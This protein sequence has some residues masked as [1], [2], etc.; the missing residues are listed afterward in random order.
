MDHFHQA[1]RALENL[2]QLRCD[3]LELLRSM[4][5]PK[6]VDGVISSLDLEL[7]DRARSLATFLSAI[8]LLSQE[9]YYD[10]AFAL[11][12]TS[13]ES[14]FLEFQRASDDPTIQYRLVPAEAAKA[15]TKKNSEWNVHG[16][17]WCKKPPR[18]ACIYRVSGHE[19]GDDFHEVRALRNLLNPNY[20]KFTHKVDWKNR[21]NLWQLRDE[22][23]G[24]SE[25]EWYVTHNLDFAGVMAKWR[26]AGTAPEKDLSKARAHFNFLSSF[27]HSKQLGEI[28]KTASR[29]Q[30]REVEYAVRRLVE[31]YLVSLMG[32][33]VRAVLRT[34]DRRDFLETE[35]RGVL[36]EI[37]CYSESAASEIA[38]PF[39]PDHPFDAVRNAQITE[40]QFQLKIDL[41]VQKPY[42]DYD[43][44][45]RVGQM[46]FPVKEIA[47]R[48][49]WEV[50]KLIGFD[51]V[52]SKATSANT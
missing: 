18:I 23:D 7:V 9:R 11:I 10:Q 13:F 4:P 34:N 29:F 20:L 25:T 45:R 38:F 43:Y 16:E 27:V 40:A 12:R 47:A 1:E 5:E 14:A 30:D 32:L 21:R 28:S 51:V 48:T 44:I 50:K 39:A 49:Q 19:T 17:S 41:G 46:T 42:F 6:A 3:I 31:L 24:I 15:L 52:Y 33:M 37:V 35:T 22:L 8:A 26:L 2:T 36:A